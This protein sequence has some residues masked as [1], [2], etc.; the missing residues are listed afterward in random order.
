MSDLN[1]GYKA[2]LVILLA[3]IAFGLQAAMADEN[4][5]LLTAEFSGAPSS[6][7]GSSPFTFA[8]TFSEAP[9]ISYRTLRDHAFETTNGDIKRAK[10][11]KADDNLRWLITVRPTADEN[12]AISLPV[13]PECAE[14]HAICTADGRRLSE[15][16]SLVVPAET[17]SSTPV[18]DTEK[19][20]I[21]T[22]NSLPMQHDDDWFTFQ[23]VFSE[24]ISIGYRDMR[25]HAF[26]VANG[27]ITK[28]SRITKGS[29]KGWHITVEPE[30][31]TTLTL[32]GNVDCGETGAICTDGGKQLSEDFTAVVPMLAPPTSFGA[33]LRWNGVLLS[34][35]A[36]DSTITGYRIERKNITTDE[37][38]FTVVHTAGE[39]DT[40][41]RNY[42]AE[43]YTEYE[44]RIA[45]LD[46][47]GYPGSYAKTA[48]T[49]RA[50]HFSVFARIAFGSGTR[51]TAAG[52]SFDVWINVNSMRL[53]DDE[54]TLDAVLRAV[55]E[56]AEGNRANNCEGS[57][58]D[59]DHSF[60]TIDDPHQVVVVTFG[61]ANCEEGDYDVVVSIA[62]GNNENE[63]ESRYAVEVSAR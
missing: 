3:A 54:E 51:E 59:E 49:T 4:P 63:V 41:W 19:P 22:F 25:D 45:A 16:V 26:V 56:D 58:M 60:Y 52:G 33:I 36:P 37:N 14:P 34:W 27:T 31:E 21:A 2:V 55:V 57:G 23:V 9:S 50:Q 18:N 32:P 47:D 12:L 30:G 13:G 17:S 1:M 6:H 29:N 38:F 48:I 40:E 42:E 28:A 7:D 39:D 8:L 35:A 61:G 10:R 11:V 24:E 44:Y 53:D 62:D 46:A 43:S 15:A 5:P 20:L